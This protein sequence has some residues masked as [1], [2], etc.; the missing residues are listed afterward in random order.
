MRTRELQC[1]LLRPWRCPVRS[2]FWRLT[3]KHLKLCFRRA[4][5][6]AT[7][8]RSSNASRWARGDQLLY[9]A[10]F[11]IASKNSN[12]SRLR[13]A[14]RRP[15]RQISAPAFPSIT[16]ANSNFFLRKQFVT[17]PEYLDY[18]CCPSSAQRPNKLTGDLPSG[19]QPVCSSAVEKSSSVELRLCEARVP[20]QA[21]CPGSSLAVQVKRSF[22]P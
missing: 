1:R 17:E 14:K 12:V 9:F 6:H 11:G 2:V 13:V 10:S 22:W 4:A 7:A 5:P 16:A 18:T 20:P 21:G 19:C 15:R 8:R 3:F